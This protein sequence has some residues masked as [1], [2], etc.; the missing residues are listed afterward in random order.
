M[1]FIRDIREGGEKRPN[2]CFGVYPQARG[3]REKRYHAE[4]F[5]R[6]SEVIGINVNG[7][8]DLKPR[9]PDQA[10]FYPVLYEQN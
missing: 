4:Y 8:S 1:S 10:M 9:T 3:D 7:R 2:P 6:I 5:K